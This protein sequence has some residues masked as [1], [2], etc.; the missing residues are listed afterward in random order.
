MILLM[1]E[2]YIYRGGRPLGPASGEA[3]PRADVQG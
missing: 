3:A 1:G 2:G